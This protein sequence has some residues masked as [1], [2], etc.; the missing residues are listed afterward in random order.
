M[1]SISK[2]YIFPTAYTELR[3]ARRIFPKANDK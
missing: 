2:L 1:T 3:S